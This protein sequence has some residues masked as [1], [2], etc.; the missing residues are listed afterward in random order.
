L[1]ADPRQS[2]EEVMDPGPKTFRPSVELEQV[3]EWMR[4]HDIRTF[5][6]VTTLEGRLVGAISRAD[7]EA[8]LSHEHQ[9][10]DGHGHR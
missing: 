10:A 8:T 1:S 9:Q 5:A 7:A 6:P 4:K 3:L 2:A